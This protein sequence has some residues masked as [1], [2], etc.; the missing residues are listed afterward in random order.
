MG[1][2]PGASALP[3][4]DRTSHVPLAAG[5]VSLHQFL[6]CIVEAATSVNEQSCRLK[7]QQVAS[8]PGYIDR[9]ANTLGQALLT[10]LYGPAVRPKRFHRSVD[11]AVLHEE[12]VLVGLIVSDGAQTAPV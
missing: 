8:Y 12:L 6:R 10:H 11:F 7:L 3:I 5:E 1:A 9:D 2:P 4:I